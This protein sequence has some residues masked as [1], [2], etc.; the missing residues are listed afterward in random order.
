MEQTQ[1][2]LNLGCHLPLFFASVI[3]LGLSLEAGQAEIARWDQVAH[4]EIWAD[5]YS[6][7]G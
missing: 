3:W 5:G 1:A 4:R 7:A 2:G 6:I